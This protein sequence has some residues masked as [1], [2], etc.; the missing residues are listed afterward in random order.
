MSRRAIS[1][2]H[3]AA[4]LSAAAAV[5]LSATAAA[6]QSGPPT[7]AD[8]VVAA[9]SSADHRA[10]DFWIGEWDV[11]N[12]A[13][14][15][16]GTSSITRVLGG[17]AL[18]EDWRGASGG[19]GRS[20]SS[21]DTVTRQWHQH[22]VDIGGNLLRLAGNLV[23][24]AMVL[25]GESTTP[26]GRAVNRVTWSRESDGRVRQHWQIST[27]GGDTWTTS[28]DGYYRRKSDPPGGG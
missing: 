20:Y 3:A 2:S 1:R 27:D 12:P 21:Y 24:G 13:G 8:T 9:C 5:F 26:N 10:F 23:D 6:A 28:F 22:W 14:A 11:T 16:A 25:E 17:C 18:H 15:Q 19:R 7:P 4:V